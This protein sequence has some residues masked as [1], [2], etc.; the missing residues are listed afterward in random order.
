VQLPQK[1]V[2]VSAGNAPLS[3]CRIE[4]AVPAFGKTVRNM[5]IKSKRHEIS[6]PFS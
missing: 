1:G 5:Q 6:L 4:I 2:Y 3:G